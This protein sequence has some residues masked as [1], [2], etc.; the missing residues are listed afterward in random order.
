MPI[1]IF[2]NY[3]LDPVNERQEEIDYCRNINNRLRDKDSNVFYVEL[4]NRPTFNTFFYLTQHYPKH[5]NIIANS[6]IYFDIENLN[7]IEKIYSESKD[8]YKLCLAL[9]RWDV[10]PDGQVKFMNR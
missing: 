2:Q 10:L 4:D 8:P 7:K 3:Y 5:I 6:D 1:N 9:T